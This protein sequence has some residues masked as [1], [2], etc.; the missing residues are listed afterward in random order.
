MREASTWLHKNIR[1][2]SLNQLLQE[3]DDG[4][5][6]HQVAGAFVIGGPVERA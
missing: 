3:V 4:T 1:R 5:H 6:P 2:S